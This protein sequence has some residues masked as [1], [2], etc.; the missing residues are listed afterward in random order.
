MKELNIGA[1][2]IKNRRRR[3]I[4]Q[5]ALAEYMGVSK[6]SVSKWET[7]AT[8]PDI[9]LLP[10][11]ATFFNISIDE[12]I[13]YEPQMTKEDIRSLYRQICRDFSEKPFETVMGQCREIT[14]KYFACT[15]LLFQIGALYVNHYM[16]ADTPEK[17]SAVL[18][19]AAELFVRVREESREVTL[20]T[21]AVNMQA[22]C[23][24]QL[25]RN[26]EV[27]ALLSSQA[28]IT[29]SP[30][31]LLASAFQRKGNLPEARRTLQA[32]IYQNVVALTNLLL[33]Y[34]E[35]CGDDEASF[36]ESCKRIFAIAETFRLKDLHPSILVTAYLCIAQEFVKREKPTQ[37]LATL[38]NYTNLVL[39]DIYPL[40]LHGDSFFNLLDEWI[41]ENLALGSDSPRDEAVIKKSML[42]AVADNPVFAPLAG[43]AEF[44]HII[45]RLRK[46]VS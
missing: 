6:A 22:L 40:R 14:R 25:G 46:C 11:L 30:E 41:E 7:G 24:L 33:P 38:E 15:P 31:P 9:T 1:N 39:S 10:R 37:A 20:Q 32:G 26:D 45:H 3:G 43:Y 21:L 28:P 12:L 29:M 19:E 8:Y 18:E 35:L 17:A 16:L 34:M 4:T 42:S 23:M 27:L 36:D 13:G 5:E 44:Q 2:L